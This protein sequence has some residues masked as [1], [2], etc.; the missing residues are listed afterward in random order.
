MPSA[1]CAGDAPSGLGSGID[2]ATAPLVLST[3]RNVIGPPVPGVS[4]LRPVEPRPGFPQA[5]HRIQPPGREVRAQIPGR[6]EIAVRSRRSSASVSTASP[7]EAEPGRTARGVATEWQ[8]RLAAMRPDYT[9]PAGTIRPLRG[10]ARAA[11]V[12]AIQA[13]SEGVGVDPALS[14]AVARAESGL[15]PTA[16]SF[17]R[18][19]VGTFQVTDTTAA[20]MRRKI[21]RGEVVRP[22]GHDDVAL[23][24]GYLRYLHD[25]FARSRRLGRDL[26]TVAIADPAERRHFAVAAYNAGEG[27]VAQ[28]QARAAAVG[29]DPT[30][31]ADVRPFLPAITQAYVERVTRF[32]AA[33]TDLRA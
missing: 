15:D 9:R 31:F 4:G 33:R 24:I 20:E 23:G 28:A 10:E 7:P 2:F 19:S 17:D 32:A 11:L 16:R 26:Q 27:R 25:I 21:E 14:L 3:V 8:Q 1:G 22:P 18:K 29:R 6:V 30:R 5:R 13:A 12:E